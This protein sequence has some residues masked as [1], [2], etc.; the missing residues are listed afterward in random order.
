MDDLHIVQVGNVLVSPDI[1]TENF[2]CDLDKCKGQCCVE[3][4]AGAPVTLDEIGGIEDSLDTVWKDMSASAQAIV[5]KQGVAY[6]D[7]EGDLVTSIVNG[8]DCVFTCY[9]NGCCLC[10]LER[11]YRAKKTDFV[12]PISCALY[13]IR[14]KEFKNGTVGINYNRWDVCKDAVVKGRELNLPVYKFLEGPLTR[15]FGAE[16]YAELCEVAE[17]LKKM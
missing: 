1:F 4:D 6:V 5:D 13:P 3:G 2:C 8:K 15:R 12:K 7:Q 11:A 16:W 17:Q 9:E 10:A 14:V